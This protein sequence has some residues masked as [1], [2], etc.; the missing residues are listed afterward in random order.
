[1]FPSFYWI[2]F[3]ILSYLHHFITFFD[4]PEASIV[5]LL[6]FNDVF[7]CVFFQFLEF[8]DKFYGCLRL[9]QAVPFRHL[10]Y[11]P[12]SL[13]EHML[14]WLFM[15]FLSLQIWSRHIDFFLWYVSN[16][17]IWLSLDW[18]NEGAVWPEVV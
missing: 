11:R 17:V 16:V 6:D 4:I 9:I 3:Q 10:I 12:T 5:I 7:A 14:S 13:M 18:V 15:L 8:F 1:M 2:N